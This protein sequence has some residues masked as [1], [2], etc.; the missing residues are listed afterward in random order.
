MMAIVA[1][2]II[3]CLF[4][5]RKEKLSNVISKLDGENRRIVENIIGILQQIYFNGEKMVEELSSSVPDGKIEAINEETNRV[6]G[7]KLFNFAKS[8]HGKRT[9]NV[10][11]KASFY[12]LW[13]ISVFIALMLVLPRFMKEAVMFNTSAVPDVIGI[14]LSIIENTENDLNIVLRKQLWD[15]TK[16]IRSDKSVNAIQ[17]CLK[18]SRAV[19]NL[20]LIKLLNVKNRDAMSSTLFRIYTASASGDNDHLMA[21]RFAEVASNISRELEG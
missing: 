4:V 5:L 1:V 21:Q 9:I 20:Y 6:L 15:A 10:V 11:I 3:T 7:L 13:D 14:G 16:I 8:Y 2:P 17:K 19:N 12:A 18:Y